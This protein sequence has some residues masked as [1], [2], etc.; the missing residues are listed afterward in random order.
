MATQLVFQIRKS[1]EQDVPLNTLFEF[2]TIAELEQALL[3]LEDSSEYESDVTLP[4]IVPD[5]KERYQ[6]FPLTEVQQAYWVGRNSAFE[7]GNVATHSYLELDCENL[8][9]EK[10]SKAWQRVIE[11]HDMLRAIVLPDGQQQV[12]KEVPPYQIEV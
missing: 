7:L 12:L 8:D 2:P 11:H 6:P 4:T 9:I 1:L 10:L 3:T 5:P